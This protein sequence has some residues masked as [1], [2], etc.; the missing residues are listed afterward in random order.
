[1]D[2]VVKVWI[3]CVKWARASSAARRNAITVQIQLLFAQMNWEDKHI[4]DKVRGRIYND[5]NRHYNER[6]VKPATAG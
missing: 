3:L 6:H 4:F 1:M 5:M 2:I